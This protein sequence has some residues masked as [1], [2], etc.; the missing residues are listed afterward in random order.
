MTQ[1]RIKV[2]YQLDGAD[3][4]KRE[5]EQLGATG[6]RSFNRMRESAI[7][8][9]SAAAAAFSVREVVQY[10]DAYKTLEN[11]VKVASDGVGNITERLDTLFGVAQRT[12]IPL[13]ATVQLYQRASMA[14]NELG[15]SQED[16]IGFT[17]NVGKALAIQGGSAQQA[18][19]A[20]LQLSQALGSGVVRAEEFNSILEGAFPIAQAAARGI[21]ETG[22]SVARLRQLISEGKITS[23]AFFEAI[24]S[25]SAELEK[26]FGQTEGTVGQALTRLDNAFTL[27]IGQSDQV[28]FGT[29]ALSSSI[30]LLAENLDTLA[31]VAGGFALLLGGR[32][33]GS[34]VALTTAKTA[35]T[36]AEVQNALAAN[37]TSAAYLGTATAQTAYLSATARTIAANRAVTTTF[38]GVALAARGAGAAMLAAFGGPVGVAILATVGAVYAFTEATEDGAEAQARYN[39]NLNDFD[40]LAAE[41]VRA[42]GQR[43]NELK[44]QTDQIIADHIRELESLRLLVAEYANADDEAGILGALGVAGQ[45]LMGRIGIGK[46]V[47]ETFDQ[48]DALEDTIKRMRELQNDPSLAGGGIGAGNGGGNPPG[49]GGA[50]KVREYREELSRSIEELERLAEANAASADAHARV[51]QQ[52]SIENEARKLGIELGSEQF[53]Q[54]EADI[55]QRD[56]LKKRIEETNKAREEE[57][58]RVERSAEI[59]KEFARDV[60]ST[61]TDSFKDAFD[62]TLRDFDDFADRMRNVFTT[63]LANLA[64]AAIAQ[65]IV[66]PVIQSVGGSLGLPQGQIDAIVG[67]FGGAP[68]GGV[69]GIGDLASLGSVFTGGGLG[70]PLF[71]SGSFIGGGID[72]IG[73][74]L[75]LGNAGF[76]GPMPAGQ[77]AP[78][79][80]AF[81]GGAALAG[82][83]G[84]MLANLL[85]LGGGIGGSIGG[86]AGGLAG[87]AIGAQFGAIGGPIGAAAGA[88]LGTALGGLF[89]GGSRPHPAAGASTREFSEAGLGAFDIGY[90]HLT[91][92][93]AQRFATAFDG[94]FNS[95]SRA[96]NLDL[97]VLNRAIEGAPDDAFAFSGGV[98]D[99]TGYLSLGTGDKNKYFAE[100]T[101]DPEDQD[102][103]NRAMGDF[104]KIVIERIADLGGEVSQTL[105]DALDNIETAGRSTE[106]VMADIAFAANFESLGEVPEVLSQTELAIQALAEQFDAAAETA[107]RLGLSIDKVRELEAQRMAQLR[108]DFN[109]AVMGDINAL[110]NPGNAQEIAVNQRFDALARDARALGGNVEAV[111]LLRRLSLQTEVANA[112]RQEQVQIAQSQMQ[113]F[114]SLARSF[115]AILFDTTL[116]RFSPMAPRER[117]A[118]FES[119][120]MGLA[121]ANDVESQQKLAELLPAFLELSSEVNGFNTEF[122]EDQQLANRLAS[123]AQSAAETQVALQRDILNELQKQSEL[124]AADN[125]DIIAQVESLLTP[126]QL[127]ATRVGR[128]VGA[129]S[130][131]EFAIN[132]LLGG[133]LDADAALKSRYIELFNSAQP[134]AAGGLISGGIPGRDSVPI[135]AMPGERIFSV[136]HSRMLEDIASMARRGANDNGGWQQV[137]ARLEARLDRLESQLTRVLVALGETITE[138]Q[139]RH[140]K[141]TEKLAAT[142]RFAG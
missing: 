30:N 85:G 10:A 65:P 113:Q 128:S 45:E 23:D 131:T 33:I 78:L 66:V 53:E 74:A 40:A 139:E 44:K 8:F 88:F 80:G 110:L 134:F 67:E 3:Q 7:R 69:G 122:A 100:V 84:S 34:V 141:T 142:P 22:G 89:G 71:G 135:M 12:R 1:R 19:G 115:D 50:D 94:F 130:E 96:A 2:R 105:L 112:D 79:S 68:G 6:E 11:Q 5:Q 20:L 36:A 42:N 137:T 86:T 118:A 28:S 119:E 92:D 49:G 93:D 47:T 99:G 133:R 75:G 59:Y 31:T 37:R 125:A 95:L 54:L 21:E 108:G 58:R 62:G 140:R 126:D 90:K 14:A 9:A 107:E 18:S 127:R 91:A 104:T 82:I 25:Q 124:M 129:L 43:A 48:I 38:G 87:T 39:G 61:L 13:D 81:T 106:E 16:L 26:V 117:L 114:E 136:P 17:E 29:A 15:A 77:A 98:D 109:A 57:A 111:E 120:I 103:M 83:G 60:S 121:G 35:L 41:M 52:I 73:N 56:R 102:D 32:V 76:I 70:Q 64:T 72:S 63:L 27:F 101:F 51:E 55:K 138:S 4:F 116:G 46:S 123:E 97:S 24:L 132:G